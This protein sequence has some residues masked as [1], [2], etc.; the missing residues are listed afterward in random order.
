MPVRPISVGERIKRREDPRLIRGLASYT[1]DLKLHGMLHAAFV[2]SDYAAGKITKI[3]LSQARKRPGV[4]AAYTFDD[5][6]GKVGRTPCIARPEPGRDSEHPLLADGFVRYVGQPLAVVI[7]ED[8]Y[9]ARDAA[10]DVQVD[11]APTRPVIDLRSALDPARGK[12][13]A[14]HADNVALAVPAGNVEEVEKLFREADGVVKL[15]LVNQKVAP[16]SMEPRAVLAHWDEGPQRLT[17][18][19]STQ[20]PH[21]VKQAVAQC[22]GLSEVRIRVVAPEVGGGFGCKIPVYPEECLLP[23]ISK[24]LR[25]PVKWAETRTEN[26]LNTTHGRAHVHQIEA[27]YRKD[28]SVL[29]LRGRVLSDVGAYPS[30]FG[31]A[32]ATFTPLMM[33][34]CYTLKGLSVEVVCLYTNTMA[35]D[36]YRGAG[37]PEAAYTAE[38]VVDAVAAAT[39]LDPVDVRRRNFIPKSAFPFTT[40]GGA[41]YD[42]GDYEAALDKAIAKFDYAGAKSRREQARAQGKLRGIGVATFTEICG[43]GPSTAASPIQRT[44]SWE[45][46]MVRVE[47]TGNVVITTGASPHGQGQE[48]AFAQMAADAFGIE[49]TDVEVLHGDTDVVTHGVGTFGSR[50]LVVGGSAVHMALEKVKAKAARIAAHLLD[51]RPEQVTF[52]GEAFR[53]GGSDRKLT[54]RQVAEAAH[55]WNV[56]VPGEEP[57]LEAVARFEPTGTTF[58]FGAHFCEVEVDRDTGEIEILRYVAVDDAGKIVNPLLAEGQRLGGIVQ[59]LGQALCEEVRYDESGQ[60]LT[61]TLMDYAMPKAH[62]F[63]R[64]ELDSTCTPTHLNPL[65]AKGIGELGTI[66]STPCLVSA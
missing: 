16:V 59:G 21:L 22:L 39:G 20:V 33:P 19:T 60:L 2:R 37:R 28:G 38:R 9:V 65:G 34:G 4:I 1:D 7:A 50:G 66:G 15:E 5:L 25:R 30:F 47:P 57:G 6:R 54:F 36:A 18:W 40:A 46:G 29:A 32:I 55:L 41:V 52:D 42:S 17:I 62:M 26:L 44:G 63:P 24:Q 3:D 10:L 23:W 13:Y 56:P 49:I 64:F 31:P 12:V 11:I 14:D 43:L 53:V 61:A 51:A 35:T 58:P 45:S 8:R 27:A 48:T